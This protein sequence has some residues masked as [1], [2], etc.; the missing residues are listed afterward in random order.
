MKR[1]CADLSQEL[2]IT[3]K[4]PVPEPLS[5]EEV[6]THANC[7][8][9]RGVV[10]CVKLFEKLF[11]EG[12]L[13][14]IKIVYLKHNDPVPSAKDKEIAVFDISFNE[15]TTLR[16]LSEAKSISIHDHHI[17]NKTVMEKFEENCFF[18]NNLSGVSLAWFF[19]FGKNTQPP[20]WVSY[21]EAR[22][23]GFFDNKEAM[24]FSAYLYHMLDKDAPNSDTV[25]FNTIYN[26]N[27][28]FMRASLGFKEPKSLEMSKFILSQKNPSYYNILETN[29]NYKKLLTIGKTCIKVM[30]SLVERQVS[31]I[32]KTKFCGIVGGIINTSTSISET[33]S[34]FLEKHKDC[35]IAIIYFTNYCG[36][37]LVHKFSL[38]SRSA[39]NGDTNVIPCHL[40]AKLFGGGGHQA[41]AG[42]SLPIATN[43]VEF[44]EENIRNLKWKE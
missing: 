15:E 21:V 5:V 34:K 14:P 28:D 23:L 10:C 37:N 39:E 31:F 36:D 9:G 16:L 29:I 20:K 30:D 22:D 40:I 12:L 11:R 38:R 26:V 17:G 44:L 1:S 8:D 3:K 18:N 27:S 25:W 19:F 13:P 35:D 4:C 7:P 6:W 24:R 43:V 42:F 32:K 2:E 41:A 33:G